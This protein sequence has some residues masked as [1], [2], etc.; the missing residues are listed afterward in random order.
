MNLK[1]EWYDLCRYVGVSNNETIEKWWI[2]LATAYSEEHR[3]YHNLDHIASC[4]AE[5]NEI[6]KEIYHPMDVK[7]SIWFH[8]SVYD[9]QSSSNEEKSCELFL[10]A[11]KDL[12]LSRFTKA[13]VKKMILA[14]KHNSNY[15]WNQQNENNDICLFLDIDLSILGQDS[16]TFLKYN[17]NIKKEYSWVEENLYSTERGKILG[18]FLTRN[19]IF[20]SKFFIK[21][22]ENK[23][24]KNIENL[25]ESNSF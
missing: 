9:T 13:S 7:L 16:E 6:K 4:L 10:Q 22:Y 20:N 21:K 24:R 15:C 23:A 5:Y 1:N 17:S 2:K 8:D 14:T 19:S 12:D 25:L 11:A 3:H 18:S